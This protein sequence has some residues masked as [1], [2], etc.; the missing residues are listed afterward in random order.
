MA[1]NLTK[2]NLTKAPAHGHH[3][4]LR[5]FDVCRDL[6]YSLSCLPHKLN[7]SIDPASAYWFLSVLRG[8]MLMHAADPEVS[9]YQMYVL[10]SIFF[11]FIFHLS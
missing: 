9:L 2:V 7:S 8:R 3:S 6:T 5:Y 1:V 4:T 10:T 11:R